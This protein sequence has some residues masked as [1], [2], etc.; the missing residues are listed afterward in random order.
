VSI[1]S[2][3]AGAITITSGAGNV[4]IVGGGNALH[5]GDDGAA[6]AVTL[7]STTA[8]AA[9]TIKG[10]TGGIVIMPTAGN[11]SMAPATDT[12]AA[13]TAAST[14]N[15]RVGC[16]TFTGFSTA[17]AGVQ[18][19]TITNNKVTATSCMLVQVTNLDASGNHAK[20]TMTAVRQAVGSFIVDTTN[21]G[22][23]ALG[24]GDNVLV[25]FWILS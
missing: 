2:S 15:S 10:G 8:G 6:N 7:G 5:L 12:Q 18:A 3:S 11:V 13:P 19:L 4:S 20:M 23:G 21:N 22:A 24:A 14:L 9:T 17:A 1:G 25:S 16:V